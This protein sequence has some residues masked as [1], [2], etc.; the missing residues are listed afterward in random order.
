MASTV[1]YR[2]LVDSGEGREATLGLYPRE[3]LAW[4][5]ALAYHAT[6]VPGEASPTWT[7][8]GLTLVGDSPTHC[9]RIIP[10]KASENPCASK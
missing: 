8:E 4:A 9:Y 10:E 3:T 1:T 6:E 2:L 5:T 7:T